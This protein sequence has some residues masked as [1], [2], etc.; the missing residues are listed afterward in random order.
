MT[1]PKPKIA[2][3]GIDGATWR[4][5][6]PWVDKGHLPAIGHMMENGLWGPLTSTI[7]PVTAPAWSSMMTGKNPG[8]H[9]LFDFTAHKPD[10]YGVTY[11]FGG[12][13]RCPTMWEILSRQGYRM[14][15][16]NVPMTYPPET[17]NGYMISGMDTPDETSPFIF[18]HSLKKAIW[19]DTG[20]IQLDIHH[21]GYMNTDEKRFD[22]LDQLVKIEEKRFSLI[23]Y[24][25]KHHPTDVFMVVFNAVDQV[26]HHFW[27]YMDENHPRFDEQGHEKFGDAI[28]NIYKKIDSLLTRILELFGDETLYMLVSDH[29]FGPAS[30]KSIR[31]NKALAEGGFLS[32]TKS[33]GAFSRVTDNID[34]VLRNTLSPR[35]KQKISNMLPWA[36]ESMESMKSTGRIDWQK[37]QAYAFEISVT[38]PNIWINLKNKRPHGCVDEK[39]YKSIVADV[40]AWLLSIKDP[41]TG[42][43]AISR[44]YEKAE[45]YS[46]PALEDAPDLTL[47]WWEGEGFTPRPSIVKGEIYH[48]P[49]VERIHEP[50]QG[51]QEWG[52]THTSDGIVLLYDSKTGPGSLTNAHITDIA[53][54]VLSALGESLGEDFDGKPLAD[55][56]ISEKAGPA[57]I[58]TQEIHGPKS[59]KAEISDTDLEKIKNRLSMLGYIDSD[60]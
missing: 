47:S 7:P 26:Q 43:R 38:S 57:P 45:I 17:I 30:N 37:T 23:E 11:T 56:H 6:R 60:E 13:R 58:K 19:R 40:K 55:F 44:V 32:F 36:R 48:G 14:G 20:G 22:V 10:A 29:G 42:H 54:T 53:P 15:V 31:L 28:L 5:I 33:S 24:L 4:L 50:I 12:K 41:D 3:I 49:V 21:L 51:G 52:G 16:V 59:D 2:I 9:G 8:K 1:N 18:P 27:H 25:Y 34:Q 46:G 39:D 35:M